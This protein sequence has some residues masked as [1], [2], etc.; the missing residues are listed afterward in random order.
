MYFYI[1]SN[2]T[3]TG[4][5]QH[6]RAYN[7]LLFGQKRWFLLPPSM[8]RADWATTNLGLSLFLT[9]IF[10]RIIASTVTHTTADHV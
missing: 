6:D 3:G 8:V 5:H 1:G 7:A 2:G 9:S 10:R 4:F